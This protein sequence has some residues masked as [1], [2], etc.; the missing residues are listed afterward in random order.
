MAQQTQID[1]VVGYYDRW[2]K[3]FPDVNSL[4][5]AHEEDVLK[6]WEGLGYYSR[7]RN[8]LKAAIV[9]VQGHGGEFPTD[10]ADI[11]G[12]PGIESTLPVPLPA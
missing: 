2:M 1:R 10:Y 5:C 8:M 11:R 9:I 6:H 4:A 3:R 12:L 7:A